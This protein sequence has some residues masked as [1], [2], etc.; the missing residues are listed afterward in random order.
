MFIIYSRRSTDDPDNQKNSLEHQEAECRRY[1]KN[2]KLKIS[3]DTIQGI[4][5]GGVIYERHTAFKSSALS[6]GGD[7]MVEYQI[8]RPKFMQMIPWLLEKKYE[9]AIVLCWDRIS[10]NEQ[11]D[12][13]VKEMIDKH[14]ITRKRVLEL[15]T[16][17]L[18]E[19]SP[20]IGVDNHLKK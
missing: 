12:L 13:I 9:G 8:E 1:A 5:E 10:R 4:M 3:D 17:I 20:D 15:C 18:T 6:F 19:C 11:S 16:G 2:N 14:G 7:G